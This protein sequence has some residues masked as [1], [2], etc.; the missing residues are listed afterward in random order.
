MLLLGDS[1]M[2]LAFW[3]LWRKLLENSIFV[4]VIFESLLTKEEMNKI[5]Q[6]N[7]FHWN[8]KHCLMR[9]WVLG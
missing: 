5:E 1:L 8:T 9:G 2:S 4:Y 7:Y 3:R 6:R